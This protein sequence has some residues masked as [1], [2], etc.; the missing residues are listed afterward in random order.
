MPS[1]IEIH[2]CIDGYSRKVLWMRILYSNKDPR[3]VIYHYLVTVKNVNGFPCR[4]RADRGVENSLIAGVQRFF[5]RREENADGSFIFGKSTGNQRIEVW[6]SY[7]NKLFL[8]CWIS[9]FK[10]FIDEGTFDTSDPIQSQCI[11]F[12]FYG[13]L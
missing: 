13:Y 10:D 12:Y 2:G 9:Y 4:V 11:R 8:G 6:W 7:L 1:G 3:T 5:S